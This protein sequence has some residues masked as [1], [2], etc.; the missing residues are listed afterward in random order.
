MKRG[1]YLP[2]VWTE[3]GQRLAGQ[4]QADVGDAFVVLYDP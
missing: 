3:R 2:T 4:L 1:D